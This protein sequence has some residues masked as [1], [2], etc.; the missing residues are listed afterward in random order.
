M[1]HYYTLA[2]K[3]DFIDQDFKQ[4]K[5]YLMDPVPENQGEFKLYYKFCM[6][7]AQEF[8]DKYTNKGWSQTYASEIVNDWLQNIERIMYNKTGLRTKA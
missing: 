4:S 1:N 3:R 8:V 5:L 7:Y 2:E 6:Q